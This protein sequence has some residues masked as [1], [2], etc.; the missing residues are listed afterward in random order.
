MQHLE[1]LKSKLHRWQ[2]IVIPLG[3]VGF[4]LFFFMGVLFLMQRNATEDAVHQNAVLTGQLDKK[5]SEIRRKNQEI[6]SLN[7]SVQTLADENETLS[8]KINGSENRDSDGISSRGTTSKS[9]VSLQRQLDTLKGE[10][11]NLQG[12]LV[13]KDAEIRQLRNDNATM[14]SKNRPLQGQ[15]DGGESGTKDQNAAS[16]LLK[17][18]KIEIQRQNQKLRDEKEV[19]TAQNKS[20]RNENTTLRNQ[21]NKT[22]QEDTNT[23]VG[24]EPLKEIQNVISGAGSHNNQGVIAFNRKDYNKAIAHFRTA[25]KTDAK[26]AIVHYNLGCTYLQ[27]K[28]FSEAISSFSEAVAIDPEFKEAYY[29]LGFAHLRSGARKEAESSVERAIEIEANYRLAR[30]L[31]RVIENIQQ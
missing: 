18:E 19:L 11:R 29:N 9:V 21:L 5:I 2:P 23:V 13:K 24:P 22:S 30:N 16:Q 12:Q 14:L 27:T 28:E 3:I 15:I 6:Q 25:I 31:L 1:N 7:T 26:P 20:L 17:E 8:Q 4:V 10:N